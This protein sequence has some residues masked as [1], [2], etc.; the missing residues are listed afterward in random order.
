M[1][2]NTISENSSITLEIAG[3]VDASSSILLD[4]EFTKVI[5]MGYKNILVDCTGLLYISSAGLGVF[6]AH[7]EDCTNA[8][9]KLVLF[10]MS[11]KIKSVFDMLGLGQLIPIKQSKEEALNYVNG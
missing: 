9:I 7:I 3:E 11:S 2:I 6:M 1:T 4:D 5:G 8:H 10:N